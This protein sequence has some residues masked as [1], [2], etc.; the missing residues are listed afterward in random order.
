MGEAVTELA[1]A[2]PRLYGTPKQPLPPA[3]AS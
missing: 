1:Q 3:A 2:D